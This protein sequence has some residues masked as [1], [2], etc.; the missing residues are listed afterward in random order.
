MVSEDPWISWNGECVRMCVCVQ[1]SHSFEV[2]RG[3]K[4]TKKGEEDEGDKEKEEEKNRA[5]IWN[6]FPYDS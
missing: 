3:K 4:V 6:L 5:G 2:G 1:R